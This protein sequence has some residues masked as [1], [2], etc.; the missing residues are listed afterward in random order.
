MTR[1]L[2][3]NIAAVIGTTMRTVLDEDAMTESETIITIE[4][5]KDPKESAPTEMAIVL[6][7]ITN[8]LIVSTIAERDRAVDII[9]MMVMII[10]ALTL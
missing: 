9:P 4:M 2:N 6:I 8:L 10:L 3:Q 1:R 7:L 5:T